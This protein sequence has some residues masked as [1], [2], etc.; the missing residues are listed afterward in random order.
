M[1]VRFAPSPTGN[2]HIGNM[3]V[4]IFNYLYARHHGGEFLLRIEDT[5]LERSTSEAIEKMKQAMAWLGLNCDGEPLYQT[6]RRPAHDEAVK[7]LLASGAAYRRDENSPVIL[8]IGAPLFAESSVSAPRDE[9]TIDFEQGEL[10]AT[11]DTIF[12]RVVSPKSGETFTTPVNWDAL[13]APRFVMADGSEIDA[14]PIREQFGNEPAPLTADS[15]IVALKFQRRYVFFDDL[16]LGRCEKP[17]DS[18]RDFTIT[19]ADGSPI[20]HLANV[21]DDIYQNVTHILRGNDHVENT[22]RHLFIFQA[23]GATP[24]AYG[25]FPMIVNQSGKP[26]SKRDGDAYVGD[27][28]ARGFL[29]D[30]LFNF[31]ALCGWA[32]GDD[33]E[34]MTRAEMIAAFSLDR[35]GKSAAQFDR[36]KLD[37]M[38]R[39]H[40]Q[41]LP[42]ADYAKLLEDEARRSGFD[43]SAHSAE[44]WKTLVAT[45]RER[46]EKIGDFLPKCRY[47]FRGDFDFDAKAVKENLLHNDGAGLKILPQIAAALRALPEWNSAALDAV[48]HSFAE[49]NGLPVG[50]VAQ[51]L[52]VAVSGA[53]ATP[54]IGETLFLVER[55]E[56]LKRIGR[57][58]DEIYPLQRGNR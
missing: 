40:L 18:L 29:P 7:Q 49:T 4:A 10:A 39:Q 37:W 42:A 32:P 53:A 5:D 6:A 31:L 50:M 8:R 54:E 36:K 14:R 15:P 23:L 21:L 57:A 30:A 24:P 56:T 28:Q 34:I 2:V 22:F 47:F 9:A 52:R 25:H 46:L 12:H 35:V 3:R 17:L 26:Y 20:F 43:P 1:R 48:A 38:N 58:M 33:R 27:F 11:R 41:R 51:P 45:Q 13:T 44:W 55:D 16:V 19:R